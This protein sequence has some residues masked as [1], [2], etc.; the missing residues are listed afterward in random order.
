[1]PSKGGSVRKR[2]DEATSAPLPPQYRACCQHE[3]TQFAS[4]LLLLLLPDS[5][6]KKKKKLFVSALFESETVYLFLEKDWMGVCG[7]FKTCICISTDAAF[8]DVEVTSTT[9]INLPPYHS[10]VA[11]GTKRWQQARWSLFS[12]VR[13]MRR[14]LLP[15]C[16][17]WNELWSRENTRVSRSCSRVASSSREL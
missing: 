8:P 17:S 14:P 16:L 10:N 15:L 11:S 9:G 6:Y 7:S 1:M 5:K 13:R 2:W 3:F 12:L 4:L